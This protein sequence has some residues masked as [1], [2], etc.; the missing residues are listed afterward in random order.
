MNI[1][2]SLSFFKDRP[3]GLDEGKK[4]HFADNGLLPS[5]YLV[6]AKDLRTINVSLAWE[7][8]E[9]KFLFWFCEE[10]DGMI[11]SRGHLHRLVRVERIRL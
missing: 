1:F 7:C 6:N 9:R 5:F 11:I 8:D 10:D 4:K 3:F 2:F